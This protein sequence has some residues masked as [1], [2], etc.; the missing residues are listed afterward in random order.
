MKTVDLRPELATVAIRPTKAN[1]DIKV[2]IGDDNGSYVPKQLL[3]PD[4]MSDDEVRDKVSRYQAQN[5]DG[6]KVCARYEAERT[7]KRNAG[8]A[9]LA[10]ALGIIAITVFLYRRKKA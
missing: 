5:K 10:G 3:Y 6:C 7:V 1:P 9:L 2:V 8:I 4:H